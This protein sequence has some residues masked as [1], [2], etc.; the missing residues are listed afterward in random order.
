MTKIS[1]NIDVL[2]IFTNNYNSRK[3]GIQIAKEINQP[4]KTISRKLNQL[5]SEGI[6]SYVYEG[7]NKIYYLNSNLS[8]F[9][10]CI[11]MIE[12]YKA[13]QFLQ[14]NPE[15]A[16]FFE[17]F[18]CPIIIFGS[19]AKN[20]Q[21]KESDMDVIFLTNQ[22]ISEKIKVF[23]VEIH[24]HFVT[25]SEFLSKTLKNNTLAIEVYKNH[26]IINNVDKVVESFLKVYFNAENK[27]VL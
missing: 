5:S 9:K 20:I 25:I 16:I 10:E 27:M 19:Y 3:Y 13:I 18:D 2:K 12:N 6:L 21:T 23:P 17:K 7:R 22:D 26:I 15:I 8:Y 11:S 1:Q 14:K 24:A 4:Q